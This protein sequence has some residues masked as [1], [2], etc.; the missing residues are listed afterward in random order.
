MKIG[1]KNHKINCQC[2][3]CKAIRK[4]NIGKNN[5]NY[6]YISK[7]SLIK[8]YIKNRKTMKEIANLFNCQRDTIRSKIHE[9]NI[10]VRNFK[11]CQL[12]RSRN[13]GTLAKEKNPNYIDN[14]TNKK[15]YCIDCSKEI[16][17]TSGLYGG[18]RCQS[19]ETIRRNFK[20][21]NNP[22]F[23]KIAKHGKGQ[24]Y[25]NIYMRSS[26]EIAYAKYLDKNNIKWLYES[27]TFN[28]ENCTYTPD[29]YLSKL[30]KYVEIKGWWR[31]KA[32]TKFNSFKKQYP[33]IK[34]DLLMKPELKE[35]GVL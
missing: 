27:K 32:K 17:V 11:E 34:I 3:V 5:F 24:Y 12:G 16:S 9:Y 19:C 23:G 1:N 13:K 2:F 30:D 18:R 10:P 22:R 25:K 8:E 31:D 7:E 21:K 26:Y 15:Y 28:L 6:K 29:F 20:G 35:L 4:E 14:R 33:K